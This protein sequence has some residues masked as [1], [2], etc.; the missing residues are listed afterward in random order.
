[1]REVC[2]IF[3][4]HWM[5]LAEVPYTECHVFLC[6]SISFSNKG[7]PHRKGLVW[8]PCEFRGLRGGWTQH[9]LTQ[10]HYIEV[11]NVSYQYGNELVPFI[12]IL[13]QRAKALLPSSSS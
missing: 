11:V 7:T 12:H 13:L 10:F 6:I 3:Q 9:L 2:S 8:G 4:E 5:G 1:M